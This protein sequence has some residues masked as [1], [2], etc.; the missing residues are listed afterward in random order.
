M[1]RWLKENSVFLPY[2][3]ITI[4]TVIYIITLAC[5]KPKVIDTTTSI[6]IDTSRVASPEAYW[7][8]FEGLKQDCK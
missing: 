2:M 7:K 4:T 3:V 8:Y 1:K 6:S 5:E